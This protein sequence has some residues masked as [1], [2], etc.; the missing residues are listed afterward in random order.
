MLIILALI[1]RTSKEK[2]GFVI[3]KKTE[4]GRTGTA[5]TNIQKA[6]KR[7]INSLTKD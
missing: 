6:G 2:P 3:S 1:R 4:R 5:D 7:L